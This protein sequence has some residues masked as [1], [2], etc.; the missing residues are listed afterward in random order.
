MS[1][2]GSIE[3]WAPAAPLFHPGPPRWHA[4]RCAPLR[5]EVARR[6]LIDHGLTDAFFPTRVRKTT[7]RGKPVTRRTL[8]LPGYLFALFPGEPVWHR[9]IEGD[10][11]RLIRGV[12]CRTSG[13]PGVLHEDDLRDLAAM[14]D[15][16]ER[17]EAERREAARIHVGDIIR[18]PALDAEAEVVAIQGKG[19][20][21]RL[22]LFD[23]ETLATVTGAVEKVNR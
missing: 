16:A 7:L 17:E 15:R 18:L 22:R 23:R 4:L 14:T 9:L 10:P 21:V 5:E 12:L 2:I 1:V 11:R 13:E 20:Q 8:F 3:P 6:H 19:V